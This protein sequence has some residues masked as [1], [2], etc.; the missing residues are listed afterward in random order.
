MTKC[1]SENLRDETLPN[2]SLH[3]VLKL[4][5]MIYSSPFHIQIYL[6]LEI[7]KLGCIQCKTREETLNFEVSVRP[8]VPR[9]YFQIL[10]WQHNMERIP[11][12]LPR[13]TANT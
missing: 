13:T 1:G 3:L 5:V 10:V 7:S 6:C 4:D 8:A 2:N 9:T 11:E 12:T